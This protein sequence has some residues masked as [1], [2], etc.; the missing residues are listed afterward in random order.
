MDCKEHFRRPVRTGLT[1]PEYTNYIG[2]PNSPI[3]PVG[4]EAVTEE[5]EEKV[6]FRECRPHTADRKRLTAEK[7]YLCRGISECLL[8]ILGKIPETARL[9]FRTGRPA[10]RRVRLHGTDIHRGNEPKPGEADTKRDGGTQGK[11]FRHEFI[12]QF[13]V[14]R[15]RLRRLHHKPRNRY[16]TGNRHAVRRHLPAGSDRP[17]NRQSEI[18]FPDTPE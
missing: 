12:R 5:P 11:I 7:R 4:R 6:T 15:P 17:P 16:A 8:D 10:E 9:P 18:R 3:F 14:V 13:P 1:E 2:N